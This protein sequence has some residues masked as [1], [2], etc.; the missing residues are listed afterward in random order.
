MSFYAM[1]LQAAAIEAELY[2]RVNMALAFRHLL[3]EEL[4]KP[5]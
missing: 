4:T 2:G 1:Q 5:Q 3:H